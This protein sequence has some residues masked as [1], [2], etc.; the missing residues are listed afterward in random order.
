MGRSEKAGKLPYSR[1]ILEKMAGK[2]PPLSAGNI[3]KRRDFLPDYS[4]GLAVITFTKK[5]HHKILR[6][7][8]F[9]VSPRRLDSDYP[10]PFSAL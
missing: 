10:P 2:I 9:S 6:F 8:S 7:F 3:H 5:S 4:I 1:S